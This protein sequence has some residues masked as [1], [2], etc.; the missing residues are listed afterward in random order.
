MSRFTDH[1]NAIYSKTQKDCSDFSARP[2]VKTAQQKIISVIRDGKLL[3][4]HKTFLD[5][6]CG[7]GQFVALVKKE[8]NAEATGVTLSKDEIQTAQKN[9]VSLIYSDMH[10][11][12]SSDGS[13][14]V[15]YAGHVIEHS[16]APL[17]AL[18]EWRRVLA[19]NGYLLIWSPVGRDFKGFDDGTV[20]YGC[21]DH[22]LTPTEWQYKWMF[23]LAEFDLVAEY[24][25]PYQSWGRKAKLKRALT[26]FAGKILS[27]LR[28]SIAPRY[29]PGT[30]A[31]FVL[32]KRP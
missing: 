17:V 28:L 2:A 19:Q 30:A 23:H 26:R 18:F 21:S 3:G 10:D 5:V 20:V 27:V 32:K 22:L 15:V 25:L 7:A 8:L 29:T 12:N 9:S 11:I 6:G 13:F 1:S 31:L 16:V 14:Q 24:D 4:E